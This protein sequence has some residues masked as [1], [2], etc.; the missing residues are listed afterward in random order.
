[1]SADR[2]DITTSGGTRITINGDTGAQ[3]VRVEAKTGSAAKPVDPRIETLRKQMSQRPAPQYID[4]HLDVKGGLRVR[5]LQKSPDEIG[6]EDLFTGFSKPEL[7]R[8]E[9]SADLL[10][11]TRVNTE[12]PNS[13]AFVT[14]L[15][16][17]AVAIKSHL[18]GDDENLRADF[19]NSSLY[20]QLT[21]LYDQDFL[22]NLS[23]LRA[24]RIEEASLK[25]AATNMLAY[26]KRVANYEPF[27]PK[28]APF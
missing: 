27:D 4:G 12:D 14:A 10:S 21:N 18:V 11:Q 19:A 7:E 15:I 1:M 24:N 9:E 5:D 17:L 2:V 13:E 8:V 20:R 3:E 26:L 22:D 25:D 6:F 28:D 16:V 23:A